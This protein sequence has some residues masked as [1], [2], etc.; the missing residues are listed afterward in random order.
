MPDALR[1]SA[2]ASSANLG[3]GFDCLALALELRNEVE[4]A[5][6]TGELPVVRIS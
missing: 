6:G 4:I 5:R 3:P 2:P 1:V